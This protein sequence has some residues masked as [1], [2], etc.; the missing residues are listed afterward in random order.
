MNRTFERERSVECKYAFSE[1]H[2]F[3]SRQIV[4]GLD[5]VS[6][7]FGEFVIILNNSCHAKSLR[8]FSLSLQSRCLANRSTLSR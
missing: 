2:P 6:N 7:L 1:L 4:Q 8:Y 3:L 5:F